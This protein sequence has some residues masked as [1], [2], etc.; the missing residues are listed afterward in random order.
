M[1][2]VTTIILV[3]IVIILWYRLRKL[4]REYNQLVEMYSKTSEE[5]TQ[6]KTYMD[7]E[8]KRRAWELFDEWRNNELQKQRAVLEEGIRKKYEAELRKWKL[9]EEKR[10]RQDAIKRS[11][12]VILG[13]VTE[14]LIPYFPD[15][16]YNP[17]DV[18]FIGTPIDFIVF[19]GMSDGNIKRIVFV[20]IKTSKTGSLSKREQQVKKVIQEKKVYWE[21]VHYRPEIKGTVGEN[22]EAESKRE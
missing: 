21:K 22:H 17:K 6:L 3:V 7:S 20:E 16:R 19:D 4:S 8:I 2:S 12:A 11:K 1:V 9:Q 10:I 13:Q 5:Y 15:F 14:H 18:R